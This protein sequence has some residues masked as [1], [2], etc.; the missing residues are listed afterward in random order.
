MIAPLKRTF[1]HDRGG[2]LRLQSYRS[3]PV[4]Q[5]G[6]NVSSWPKAENRRVA[7]FRPVISV[8][9]TRYA[10]CEPFRLCRVGP[11]NFTPS[12][13]QI[14]DVILLHHPW[15][16]R[17]DRR[18]RRAFLHLPYSYA[19]ALWTGVTRDTRPICDIWMSNE[20][21]G[22]RSTTYPAL[23]PSGAVLATTAGAAAL[24][25]RLG[26]CSGYQVRPDG[27]GLRHLLNV[28]KS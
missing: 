16:Q 6:T 20:L 19:T 22:F 7:T 28:T 3:L 21:Q 27:T 9:R 10:R 26:L 1:R 25:C 17:P 23:R 18:T 12:L 24:P 15:D 2:Q 14:P 5:R 11:G 13:S 8:L 4:R